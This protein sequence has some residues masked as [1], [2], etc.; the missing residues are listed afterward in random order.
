MRRKTAVVFLG[1]LTSI[2]AWATTPEESLYRRAVGN[3]I[4]TLFEAAATLEVAPGRQVKAVFRHLAQDGRRTRIEIIAPNEFRGQ[5]W[6]IVDR[7]GGEDKIWHFDPKAQRVAEVPRDQ[8][9]APWLGSRFTL[10]DFLL[11]DPEAYNFELGGEENVAG[12]T[13]TVVRLS[14]K[15]KDKDRY[16]VRVYSI[17]PRTARLARGLFFDQQGRAVARWFVERSEERGGEWFPAQQKVLDLNSQ[18]SSV[19]SLVDFRYG[20]QATANEFEPNGLNAS[21][22][23]TSGK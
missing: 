3:L 4:R 20:V 9:H 6:L 21:L 16:A 7:D 5:R 22:T 13:F 10:A 17:A 18:K 19:L 23:P 12:E 14:P 11:P 15:E 1:L 8:W 2:P